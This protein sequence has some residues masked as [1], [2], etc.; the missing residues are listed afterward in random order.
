VSNN[1]TLKRDAGSAE[2]REEH[3]LDSLGIDVEKLRDID[4]QVHRRGNNWEKIRA[5]RSKIKSNLLR[6]EL[7]RDVAFALFLLNARTCA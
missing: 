2:G 7:T 1:V 5:I 4:A 6:S 3:R